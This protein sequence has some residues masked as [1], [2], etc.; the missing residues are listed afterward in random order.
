MLHSSSSSNRL[1]PQ[2]H[3]HIRS[4]DCLCRPSTPAKQTAFKSILFGLCF[5]HSLLLGRKKFG[6][7]IGSGAG[8]GLG[9][10]RGYSFNMGDLTT[11]G[12]VLFNYLEA[13]SAV[14]WDD[15]RYMFGEVFYGGH[16][17]DD[18]DRRCCTTYLK[19]LI[20][21]E[22][23]PQGSDP[24]SLELAPGFK[25]P[26]PSDYNSMK[27][28]IETALPAESPI[29]YGMHTNAELSLLTSQVTLCPD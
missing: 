2:I 11:C 9:F 20:K 19:V 5:Y 3:R 15:L 17:T 16:I 10:C 14:P 1:T 6:T 8:S 24:P 22:I 12:D 27:E 23:M 26:V 13:N 28:Y 25:A 21:P 4:A 18:Y 29:M 7:G